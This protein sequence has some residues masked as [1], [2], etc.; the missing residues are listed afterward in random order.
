MSDE[1]IKFSLSQG[2]DLL[3]ILDR[4]D[5]QFAMFHSVARDMLSEIVITTIKGMDA[6]QVKI[7]SQFIK[8][9]HE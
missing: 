7:L 5:M 6:H 4:Y 2:G 3:E 8:D 9:H 1:T